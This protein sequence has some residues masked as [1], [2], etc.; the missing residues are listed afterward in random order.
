MN[1]VSS[2]AWVESGAL[3]SDENGVITS[4][5]KLHPSHKTAS[6]SL[7]PAYPSLG[8]NGIQPVSTVPQLLMF[9]PTSVGKLGLAVLLSL[10]L[11]PVGHFINLSDC[12]ARLL[13]IYV[14]YD[15]LGLEMLCL[16]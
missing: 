2:S 1:R 11:S 14:Q 13:A 3:H 10:F 5:P 6:S 7:F 15:L 8:S 9:S 12:P 4:R 16:L